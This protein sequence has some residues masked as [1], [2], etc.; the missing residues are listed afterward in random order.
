MCGRRATG[1]LSV[2]AVGGAVGVTPG[3]PN[4]TVSPEESTQ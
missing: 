3:R 4:G 1:L 2:V